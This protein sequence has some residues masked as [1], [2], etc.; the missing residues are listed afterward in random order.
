MTLLGTP[1]SAE[2]WNFTRRKVSGIAMLAARTAESKV[3]SH[4]VTQAGVQW[5]FLS[6]LQPLPPGSSDSPTSASQVVGSTG[7]CYHA[8]LIFVF[9]VETGFY[10]VGQA[11]LELQTSGNPPTLASQSAEI[12]GEAP[13]ALLLPGGGAVT[14]W[15][16]GGTW[17]H[18]ATFA[19][20]NKHWL[21]F[22]STHL[23][24]SPGASVFCAPA[25]SLQPPLLVS[26][27]SSMAL[28]TPCSPSLQLRAQNSYRS[29]WL[30]HAA[31]RCSSLFAN[32]SIFQARL[33][34][35]LLHEASKREPVQPLLAPP[36][37]SSP[38]LAT[39]PKPLPLLKQHPFASPGSLLCT[40]P[41][42]AP[43]SPSESPKLRMPAPLG[44]LRSSFSLYCF[45]VCSS[46][47][48][49]FLRR[50][51]CLGWG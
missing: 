40:R 12:I 30:V 14:V 43:C 29:R 41:S 7:V 49:P 37:P 1:G 23:L 28:G 38:R 44:P 34:H 45:P 5:C 9:L 39:A 22:R 51:F 17:L 18:Q 4:S 11:G 50:L 47:I 3:E 19:E 13:Q 8:W 42:H 15:G 25:P 21:P 32:P 20:A 46:L 10:H 31:Q 33:R 24:P 27:L 35:S 26:T 36:S 2:K 16:L 6:S 48:L